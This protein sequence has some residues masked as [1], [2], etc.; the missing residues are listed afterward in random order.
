LK[1]SQTYVLHYFVRILPRLSVKTGFWAR[2]GD[3]VLNN[4]KLKGLRRIHNFIQQT[5]P[6][7]ISSLR[8]AFS[9]IYTQGGGRGGLLPIPEF[10][11]SVNNI[12]TSA[13]VWGQIMPTTILFAPPP[14]QGFEN[15]TTALL[16]FLPRIQIL[17]Q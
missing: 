13:G 1:F 6:Y 16:A 3:A 4:T 12:L 11:T 2:K 17:E 9:I 15:L 7:G 5:G 10:G 14:T 8:I